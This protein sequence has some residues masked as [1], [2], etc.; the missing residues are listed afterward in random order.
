MLDVH[1]VAARPHRLGDLEAV[2]PAASLDHE[3]DQ[4]LSDVEVDALAQ[5]RDVDDVRSM[6][7]HDAQ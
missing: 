5:V 7:C 2:L 1:V 4:R 6:I 3:P